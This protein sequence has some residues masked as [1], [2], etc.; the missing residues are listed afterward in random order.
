MRCQWLTVLSVLSTVTLSHLATPPAPLWGDIRVKHTWNS[1]PDNWESLGPPPAGTTLDL[2]I[3][4]K[5]HR[6]NALIDSLYE[7]SD[8]GHQKYGVHLSKEEVSELVAPHQNTLKLVHS[9]LEHHGVPSSSISRTHGDGWLTITSVPVSQA[10]ELLCASYQ[11]YK[12]TG[13][14]EAETILRTVGYSLPEALHGHVE[15]VAPTTY[16]ASPQTLT[17]APRKRYSAEAALMMNVTSGEPVRVLSRDDE[18]PN[19]PVKPV[20]TPDVLRWLYKTEKYIPAAADKNSLGIMGF[21]NEYPNK[22]DLTRFM[23]DYRPDAADA[24]FSVAPVNGGGY[25]PSRPGP[26]ASV[27]I[28]YSSAIA[29]PTPQIFYSTGGPIEWTPNGFPTLGDAYL[30]W[31]KYLLDEPYIPPT[32]GISYANPE[33][34][35][36]LLYATVVCNIFAQ[37]GLRGVSVLVAT[38]DDGVGRGDCLDS[39]GNARFVTV[40]PASCPWVTSVGGTTLIDPEVAMI[41]SGGGF[42]QYFPRPSYQDAAVLPYLRSLGNQYAGL[43][44]ARGR[45]VPDLAA[46]S[47]R[48]E[49]FFGDALY[50]V[51]GTSCS[52]PTITGIISLLNDY[53]ISTGRSPLGFLNMRLYGRGRAGLNDVKSGH[54][55]GCGTEGFTATVGWDPVTGLGTPDFERLQLVLDNVI[56]PT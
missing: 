20:I 55:Q 1:V 2:Y 12:H 56:E 3:A 49:F 45:G 38:G 8:P 15:T 6:G 14:N 52:T 24:T 35:V 47:D 33:T 19:E 44:N 7:V 34:T 9:W 50:V 41:E 46:Q 26:E 51:S 30:A 27:D 10:D 25:D 17:Q 36:P 32:I 4:L 39:S 21:L 22:A 16:F 40:F 23:I 5:P 31:L 11:L 54:N 43:Y 29:Y 13:K 28:Q 48:F 18:P 37:L 53:L 42:S